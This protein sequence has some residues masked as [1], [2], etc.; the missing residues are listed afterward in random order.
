MVQVTVWRRSMTDPAAR[1]RAG[2]CESAVRGRQLAV[3]MVA[4]I[5]ALAA[6]D[7][8]DDGQVAEGAQSG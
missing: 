7:G 6:G 4:A 3:R 1:A 8:A 5:A 2:V